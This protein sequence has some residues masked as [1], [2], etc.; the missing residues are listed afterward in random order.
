ME[1]GKPKNTLKTQL[2]LMALAGQ[3][4][5]LNMEDLQKVLSK[6]LPDDLSAEN[7]AMMEEGLF[8]ARNLL[9]VFQRA[10]QELRPLEEDL[11]KWNPPMDLMNEFMKKGPPPIY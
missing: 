2:E 9:A 1:K 6:P 8:I 11:A 5:D 3:I 7:R 4:M 10:Q